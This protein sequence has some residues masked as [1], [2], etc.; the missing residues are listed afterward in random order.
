[1][2]QVG[3]VVVGDWT[4]SGEDRHLTVKI[5]PAK[6]PVES[7]SKKSYLKATESVRLASGDQLAVNLYT[8]K[9]RE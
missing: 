2:A 9:P 3:R 8:P 4:G 5:Y 6:T 7:A 1:M